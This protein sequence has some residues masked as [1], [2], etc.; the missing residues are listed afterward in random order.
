MRLSDHLQSFFE[1]LLRRNFLENVGREKG[2][3]RTFLICS[4]KHYLRDQRQ[5]EMATKRGG[6][7][8]LQSLEAADTEGRPLCQPA[9]AGPAPDVE[10]DRA[11]ARLLLSKALGQLEQ[12]CVQAGKGALF[13][14]LR[15]CIQ[16]DPAALGYA[17]IGQRLGM[18][19]GAVKVAV[20]RLKARLGAV[21]A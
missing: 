7:Q 13:A 14:A 11:W 20:H 2:R 9:A 4:L 18:T 17:A 3:F 21:G 15:P 12:E 16:A 10:F 1:Q 5:K 8:Q 19:E 6:G